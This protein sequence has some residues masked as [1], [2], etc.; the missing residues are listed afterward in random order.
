M[1]YAARPTDFHTN[2]AR[3]SRPAAPT[4]APTAAPRAG[5]LSRLFNAVFESRQQQAERTVEA[6]LE[7]TGHRFTDSVERDINEHLFN[8]G[9]NMRR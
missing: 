9:W 4:A 2:I 1:T 7:R 3:Y 6:Y 5:R 8:G